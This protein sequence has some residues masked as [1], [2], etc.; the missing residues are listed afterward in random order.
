MKYQNITFKKITCGKKQNSIFYII[1]IYFLHVQFFFFLLARKRI[2]TILKK[3]ISYPS[4]SPQ[5]IHFMEVLF[6]ILKQTQIFESHCLTLIQIMK[7]SITLFE[8]ILPIIIFTW[9]EIEN[10]VQSTS[11]TIYF[12]IRNCLKIFNKSFISHIV[13]INDQQNL[14]KL[15]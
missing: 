11:F 5:K 6:R 7:T 14:S 2:Q 8:H 4:Y 10:S 9:D 3:L 1:C 15:T 12:L 13:T